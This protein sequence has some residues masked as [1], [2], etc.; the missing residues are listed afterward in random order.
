MGGARIPIIQAVQLYSCRH[1]QR[2]VDYTELM[3]ASNHGRVICASC[4]AG[5]LQTGRNVSWFFDRRGVPFTNT[6][7][8]NAML[9]KSLEESQ[10]IIWLKIPAH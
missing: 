6:A 4:R 10:L 2:P 7:F 8:W 1:R 5:G 3:L 9:K